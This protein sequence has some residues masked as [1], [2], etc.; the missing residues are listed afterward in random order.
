MANTSKVGV[1]LPEPDIDFATAICGALHRSVPEDW[2]GDESG[3]TLPSEPTAGTGL[4]LCQA[5]RILR[6]LY[7]FASGD[8]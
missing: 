1:P 5:L 2:S 6:C 4:D 7:T 8:K 3:E